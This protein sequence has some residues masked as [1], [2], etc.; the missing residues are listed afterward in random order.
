MLGWGLYAFASAAPALPRARTTIEAEPGLVPRQT[1]VRGDA[2]YLLVGALAAAALQLVG[3]NVSTPERAVLVRVVTLIA[4]LGLVGASA[5]LAIARHGRRAPLRRALRAAAPWLAGLVVLV[6][7]G[8]AY[9]VL[10]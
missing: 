8:A 5:T 6:A 3:W 4:G 9:A 1:V 10:D 2:A 7:I